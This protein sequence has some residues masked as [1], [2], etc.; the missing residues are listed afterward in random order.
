MQITHDLEG[1]GYR[2]LTGAIDSSAMS[3]GRQR[4]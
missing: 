2:G 1:L 4:S 3:G